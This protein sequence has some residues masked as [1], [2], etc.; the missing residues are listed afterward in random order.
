MGTVHTKSL[1]RLPH[2]MERFIRPGRLALGSVAGVRPG[3]A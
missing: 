1:G 3:L 2:F